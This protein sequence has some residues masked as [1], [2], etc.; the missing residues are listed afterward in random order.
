MPKSIY[1]DSN[2]FSNLAA[3]ANSRREEDETILTLLQTASDRGDVIV[4][5]SP[6]LLSEAVH[7]TEK[8]KDDA[9]RRAAL[10]RDLCDPRT[11]RFPTEV[12]RL[13][14]SRA[15]SGN[16]QPLLLD[17]ILSSANEWF[18]FKYDASSLHDIRAEAINDLDCRLKNQNFPRAKRRKLKSQLNLSKKTSHAFWRE[19]ISQGSWD[20]T[21]DDPLTGLIDPN[22]VLDWFLGEKADSEITTY[23]Q[24]LLGDPY[25]LFDHVVDQT[26]H[27]E[28]LYALLRKGGKNLSSTL[29][30]LGGHLMQLCDLA[31]PLG[32]AINPRLLSNEFMSIA[33]IRKITTALAEQSVDDLSET[34]LKRVIS[35]CPST[36][37]LFYVFR[38]YF[39][40]LINSNIER[41]RNGDVSPKIPKQSD[42]GDFMHLLYAPYVDIF[43]CDAA[44]GELLKGANSVSGRFLTKRKNLISVLT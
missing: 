17:D 25:I 6:A 43:R 37:L 29:E 35:Q 10:M 24:R 18:G 13:E 30:K 23:L 12:C 14:L 3:P 38:R 39:E 32:E 20:S 36:A 22:L 15:L 8:N 11:L 7:A 9:L 41:W 21:S 33:N 16:T 42:F 5:L 27:R 4:L 34:D 26:G 44:F 1:L 2:D 31:I 19:L 40:V 28:A